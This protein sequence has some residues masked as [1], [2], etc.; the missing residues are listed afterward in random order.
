MQTVCRNRSRICPVALVYL[1]I[2]IVGYQSADAQQD[3]ARQAYAIFE[4]NCLN[5]HGEHGAYTEQLIIEHAA[6]VAPGGAVIPGNP[7][8]S[9]F[10]QRLIETAPERRMPLNAPPLTQMAIDTIRD[11]IAAGAPDWREPFES[12]VAFITPKEMLGT[13]ENHVNSLSPFDRTF[14]R[15]FTLTHLY[16]AGETTE[17]LLAYRRA[18]SKLVNSLS[19]GRK[20]SNP[21]PIDSE[22]TIFYIDLR[23]YEWEIG[24]NRW[25]LIEAEY[26]YGIDFNA[27]TQTA[28]R[29]KLMNLR[30]ELDCEVPFVPVDWFLATASLP[31]LYHDILGLPETDRELETRLEVNVVENLRNAAGR[32]VW[33]AG[34]NES[35]VSNHNRVVE[36]HESRYGAYWKSYDF[37]GSVGTQNIFTHPLSFTHDGGEI[38]FNL[39]NG[40][41]AYLLVDA[42]GNR[43]NTAPI[44]IVRNPAASDPTV[45]NGLSCIGCHTEGMK[46]FE[47][48]VR[49]VVEQNPNPPF[50]KDRALRLYTD[51]A[52]MDV[53]VA[54]DTQRYREALWEAGG[55][56]GG[57]EP[58]QRF[59]EVFQGPV[60][61]AHAAAAVGLET[62]AF[63]QN[64]RQNT[65]L[66]HLGLL[67]L[68]NGIMKRDTWTEQFSEV[69][70]ALDFP[71]KSAVNPIVPQ[72]ERTPRVAV[73]IPD[74]NLRA[75]IEDTLGKAPGALITAE[76]MATLVRLVAENKSIK[77]LTGL[78]FAKNLTV[79][80]IP[81]NPLSDLSPLASLT[82]LREIWLL[83][84]EVSDLSPLVSSRDLEVLN[85][86]DTRISSLAPLAGLKNLKTLEVIHTDISDLLPLAGL[87]NLTRLLLYNSKVTDLSPLKGLTKLRWLGLPHTLNISDFSP[88]SGLTNLKHLD[89][90]HTGISD[91]SPLAGLV[92]LE[93]LILARNRIVDASPLVSLQRLKKLEL[94]D[95]DISDFSSLNHISKNI[96]I[97]NWSNNPGFPQGG[98]KI[99][100]PWLWL[101]LPAAVD[102]D[103][104]LVDYLARASNSKFTEQQTATFGATEDTVIGNSMWSAGTL[105]PYNSNDLRSNYDN[106]KRLLKS[107]ATIEF[108]RDLEFMVYGV[109]TLYSPRTQE[110]KMF[111]GASHGRK[112]WLNGKLILYAGWG[113]YYTGSESYGYQTFYP[114][115]LQE[116]KNV[117]LVRLEHLIEEGDW[118]L[119]FG[120]EPGTE[121]KVFNPRVGY[122]LSDS[123]IHVGDT[124]TL[125]ISAENIDDLAGWQ[126]DIVFNP[127]VLEA[128]EIHEGE[129]L[130]SKGERTFFQ[131]GAID[132]TIGKITEL[133]SAR[134]SEDGVSGTGTLLSVIFTA[135]ADG[136]TQLKL[137][138]FQLAS[139]TGVSIPAG[140]REVVITV[141][142][143][144]ATG[145]V[146]RDGQ[147][148]ILDMV[149]VA[150]HFGKTVPSDSNVDLNGDGV[151]NIQDLIIVAQHLGESTVSAAPSMTAEELN[152]AM[153]QA[154]IAQA[155]VENDGS[156]AF[157]QGIANLKRL[158][159]SLIPEKT[160]LLP[161]YPNPFNPETW[162]PYQLSE[163]AE[164]TLTIYTVNGTKVRTLALGLMPAGIYQSRSR[165]AYWDGKNDVGESVA[166]GVYFYTLT[167]GEFTSTRK[168]LIRK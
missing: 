98:P 164:V 16:N 106:V 109:I 19:W 33:R 88:L 157:Q 97:F 86:A 20:I 61:A 167:A 44:S 131:K 41:Q 48:E 11:W 115:T 67:V 130:M 2:F 17:A 150:R 43:L 107:Q 137:E 121:Y 3:I 139:I 14:A 76:D 73:S 143:R 75:V 93:T 168:M 50:N 40:L 71:E 68:E 23:D 47:D 102:K 79:L 25:T 39:P 45:R 160:A 80:F 163:P 138:N 155:Q 108:N 5:C 4:Q 58:I 27:P 9:E 29:E 87:T 114:I 101:T 161:N 72:T 119:F 70:F 162:I 149:L 132:N 90:F 59:H 35:G 127:S 46:V 117:F 96:E 60:D 140:P 7:Q 122:T 82:K 15:Y 118:S 146:N 116:G 135:K 22:E 32:R 123:K 56:F 154:W 103:G 69:V 129:F 63:L 152:P 165:A 84:T 54:E 85:I 65:S 37:A 144:L 141:E 53:L 57:I 74:P 166:S 120:F 124:F 145:D 49:G 1:L 147:V 95:N 62:E 28:L 92:N 10:Y 126:F 81:H 55:V 83:H 153:V 113:Y 31:P 134:L 128:V 24:T 30:K 142:G 159:A 89:L 42:G 66:Q 125:D 156:I 6:L 110:T 112:L 38:I 104:P 151:I 64:I 78:Q 8:A 133:S 18:L 158:L 105:E 12:D 91:I 111:I 13:I 34:F 99:S 94:Q 136:Q 26:P 21:R 77:D 36:R 100:G 52:T 51:Q 148:S